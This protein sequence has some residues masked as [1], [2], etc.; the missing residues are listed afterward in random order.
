MYYPYFRGKQFELKAIRESAPILASAGFTPIIEPVRDEQPRSPLKHTLEELSKH[1]TDAIVIINPSYGYFNDK[2]SAISKILDE[3]FSDSPFIH[4]AI[5]LNSEITSDGIDQLLDLTNDD[6]TF[7]HNGYNIPAKLSSKFNSR[8]R[9]S[10]NIF[11]GNDPQFI[12][13]DNFASSNTH[14]LISDGFHQRR[15]ADY[16]KIEEFSELHLTYDKKYELQGFGDFLIVGDNYSESGG[17]AYAVAIHLTFIDSAAQDAMFIKHY[18]SD[19]NSGPEDTAG[20]FLEALSK[21]IEDI[22][23]Q[24]S[25]IFESSAIL[26]FK[27]L[28]D[29]K[30]FPNLGYIKKLS[31][32]HHIETYADY[33][34]NRS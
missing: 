12:Y 32:I 34:R 3:N 7:I 13:Q 8:I 5:L 22:D 10:K 14:I 30:H 25:T 26:E 27:D 6:I 9:V 28:Y 21:L 15:N 24:S 4:K 18:I 19:S 2:I 31:M 11:I 23:G 1:E 29:L 16:P 17:P 20:K 33:F